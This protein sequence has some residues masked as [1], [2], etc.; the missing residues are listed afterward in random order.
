MTPTSDR[1][2]CDAESV[3]LYAV[4]ALPAIEASTVKAHIASCAYCRDEFEVL[5]WVVD[6]F[7][8][9]QRDLLRPSESVWQRL[10][11][12]IVQDADG[13][14]PP[15]EPQ[16]WPEPE[17]ENV[18][19]GISCKVLATDS[20]TDRITMLVRLGPGVDYPPHTHAD[21]EELYLLWGELW[22]DNRKLRPGDY[23]RAERGSADRRVWSETG[24]TCVLMTSAQDRL[25]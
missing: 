9:G 16:S 19:P 23:N 1:Y 11:A 25:S 12:R 22:I 24:C 14:R 2:G 13:T 3:S 15:S 5:R 10:E 8:S 17:W 21:V 4:G 18:A 6:S 20:K 7:A